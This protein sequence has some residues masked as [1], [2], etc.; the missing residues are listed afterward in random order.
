[1]RDAGSILGSGRSSGTAPV[2]SPGKFHG[3][4]SL[5]GYSPWGPKEL[6]TT[7]HK[8]YSTSLYSPW[9]RKVLDFHFHFT[10]SN[11]K[12][13]VTKTRNLFFSHEVSLGEDKVPV[14]W[15]SNELV[16]VLVRVLQRNITN[17][18][19]VWWEKERNWFILRNWLTQLWGL[20]S[21]DL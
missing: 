9:S 17:K 12:S 20:T 4:R 5:M 11:N 2:F 10:S 7:E 19:C 1:M 16:T 3:Q 15:K 6:D 21:Q 13:Q 18:M 8:P 14:T